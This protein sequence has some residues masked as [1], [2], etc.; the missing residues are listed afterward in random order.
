MGGRTVRWWFAGAGKRPEQAAAVAKTD[1]KKI[2][3][4]GDCTGDGGDR[5]YDSKAGREVVTGV[6]VRW[7]GA[8]RRLT[9]GEWKWRRH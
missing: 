8:R 4:D 5:G 1:P 6:L 9:G 7:S 3:S 2:V